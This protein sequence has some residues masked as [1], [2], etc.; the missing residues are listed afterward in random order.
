ME[1]E[2]R[3]L[4]LDLFKVSV[5]DLI[6]LLKNKVL[7]SEDRHQVLAELSKRNCGTRC[8]NFLE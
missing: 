1:H 6:D 3:V 5:D 2:K 8:K 7:S 4:K